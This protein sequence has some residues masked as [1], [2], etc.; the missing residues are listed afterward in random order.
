MDVDIEIRIAHSDG[1]TFAVFLREV[2]DNGIFGT[3]GYKLRVVKILG[4][5]DRIDSESLVNGEIFLPFD[6]FGFFINDISVIG[7][8]MINRLQYPQRCAAVEVGFVK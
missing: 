7:L 5:D 2:I 1:G 4:I 8:E 3:V 6:L